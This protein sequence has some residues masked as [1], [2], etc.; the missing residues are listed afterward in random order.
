MEKITIKGFGPI[1]DAEIEVKKLLVLIGEQA[2][3]KST[4]AKLIYFFKSIPD[5]FFNSYHDS[6]SPKWRISNDLNFQVRDLFY[7]FFGS[8]RSLPPF[9]IQYQ[10]AK[11]KTCALNL[12]K[13]GDLVSHFS[14]SILREL[15]SRE[16]IASKE[17]IL[18]L[19]NQASLERDVRRRLS[20]ENE[21]HTAV[22]K[23]SNLIDKI[24]DT[25]A[26]SKQYVVAGRESTVSFPNTYKQYLL[27]KQA[28]K[29]ANLRELGHQ[30]GPNSQTVDEIL[31]EHFLIGVE[32]FKSVFR[33]HGGYEGIR[34]VYKSPI[35]DSQ[36]A[37][38]QEASLKILKGEYAIES[39]REVLKINSSTVVGLPDTSSGQKEAIRV[40]QGV[41]L[42]VLEGR[43]TFRIIEEPEA[44]LFPIAQKHLIELLVFLANAKPENQV[45]ITTHSPYVL[46]TL[47]NLLLATRVVA[48]NPD[49]ED[50]VA[51]VAPKAFR[52][53]PTTFAAYSLGN[54]FDENEPYCANIVNPDTGMISQNY[55]DTV[56]DLL[57]MEFDHL[58][59]I[60]LR[61]FRRHGG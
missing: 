35:P 38:L 52:I 55:L 25:K 4:I 15:A 2:S 60:H 16:I 18:D 32:D 1:Q 48:K 37:S 53:D 58:R 45:I 12:N 3:G 29:Y 59:N 22:E 43:N 33:K 51:E 11:Q 21:L 61:S 5:A 13:N 6:E 30:G 27:E 24:F 41:L 8:T 28:I 34:Q 44:H 46:T 39:E 50:E 10:F 17:K 9:E 20:V 36:F 57:G 40:I 14:D 47:N 7:D 49:A 56:S 31:L 19:K 26:L 54:S 23:L 42:A